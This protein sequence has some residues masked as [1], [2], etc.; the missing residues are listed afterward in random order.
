MDPQS[1]EF[2]CFEKSGQM[3]TKIGLNASHTRVTLKKNISQI[4]LNGH[5]SVRM[6]WKWN[7]TKIYV[8]SSDDN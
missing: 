1:I 5:R 7:S 2:Q 6:K 4:C 8:I 3:A